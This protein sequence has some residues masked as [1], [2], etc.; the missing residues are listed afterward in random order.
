MNYPNYDT[1]A[2]HL[3]RLAQR[4]FDASKANGWYDADISRTFGDIVALIH[5]EASEAFEEYRNGRALNE[6]YYNPDKPTKPEGVPSEL[7]DIVIRVLD[8]CGANGIDIGAIVEEKLA[9][10]ATRGHRHGGKAL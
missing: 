1:T 9:Y 7:A 4:C 6:T 2:D 5:T 10:N 8:T 3:N